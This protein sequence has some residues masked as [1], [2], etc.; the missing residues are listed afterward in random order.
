MTSYV[1]IDAGFA[2]KLLTPNPERPAL[3]NL[4]RQWSGEQRVLCAPALWLY[5]L[6]S[7]LT[8]SIHFGALDAP[9]ARTGLALAL[10]LGVELMAPD[11]AQAHKAF[12]WTRRL[13][14]AAAYDSFYLA[15]AETLACELWTA[16]RRLV[17]AA[18]QPW[19][20]LAGD[21]PAAT[22]AT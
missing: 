14:R 10:D 5:E 7:I 9:S 2:F 12:E 1:A 17:N 20:R 11:E 22:L 21:D 19:V 8:K 4:V 16:D 3:K 15:V 6:T 18:N 13:K